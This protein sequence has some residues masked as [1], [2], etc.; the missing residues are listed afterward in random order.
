MNHQTLV[1]DIPFRNGISDLL[2]QSINSGDMEFAH[3]VLRPELL[4]DY[5]YNCLR[6]QEGIVIH[7][8]MDD[9]LEEYSE[10]RARQVS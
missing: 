4:L 10:M 3:R 7:N 1:N 2:S 9:F 5:L 8:Q 6:F